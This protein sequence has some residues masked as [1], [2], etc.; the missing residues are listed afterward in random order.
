MKPT[1]QRA[2]EAQRREREAVTVALCGENGLK[3]GEADHIVAVPS[4]VGTHI[5]EVHL[6]LLHVWCI[7]VDAAVAKGRI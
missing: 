1:R 6:M 4:G 5:Q 2:R 3:G 7:A